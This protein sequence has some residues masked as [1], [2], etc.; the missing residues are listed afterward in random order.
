MEQNEHSQIRKE[1]IERFEFLLQKGFEQAFQ[2]DK[3]LLTLSAGALLLSITFVGTLSE[4]KHG[5]GFLFGAW[6]CFVVSIL[7]V[8]FAMHRAQVRTHR[9]TKELADH[10][11]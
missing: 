11:A 9:E 8:I 10:V 1:L 3:S 4:T 7:A 5:L 2:L 6:A